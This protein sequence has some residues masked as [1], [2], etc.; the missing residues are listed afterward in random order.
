MSTL[1]QYGHF[2]EQ[3]QCFVLTHE[4][5]RKWRNVHY[6]AIGE[7]EVYAETSNIGDGPITV[8]DGRGITCNL[9]GWDAKYIYLRDDDNGIAFCPWGAPAPQQVQNRQCRFY[10]AKT[11]IASECNGLRLT[12]R[13]FVPRQQVMEI[14][15][16]TVENLT[17]KPRHL[18]VFG[19]AMFQLSGCD[20]EGRYVGKENYA[21]VMPE[22]GGTFITNR[23]TGAPSPRFK[24]YLVALNDFAGGN[25]YRDQFTRSEFS[26]GTPK[27]LWGWNC[28]NQPA[29]GP[30]C[31]GIVQAKIT[32]APRATGRV[33]FL[34]GQATCPEDVR[35]LRAGI[36]PAII[37]TWCDEQM[38]IETAR[39]A[40]FRVET[41][42]VNYD[43]LINIFVKKQM[44]SYLINKSGFRDNLQND[45][46]LAM[47][48][49]PAAEANLLRALASQY[50]NGSVPHGFR[51]LNRLQYSDK[52]AWTM[53]T[54]PALVKESGR[55]ALLDDIVPYFESSEKGTVWDHMLRAMRFLAKD[56]G[57]HG[58]CNQHHADW[59]DGLEATKEAGERESVMVTQQ[60]CYGLLE[61]EELARRRG[62]TAVQQEAR[63]IYD[64]FAK[65]LNEI[66]WDGEWY[67]RTFCGDGYKIGSRAN[68]EGQIF[69]NTQSWAV[70]SRTA[71]P[72]RA[73][74][75]MA[76]VDRLIS[77]DLGYRICVPGFSA[78]DPR[79][80]RMSNSMP[81]HVENG[82]CYNHA[83]GFKGV[84]DC[85]LGRAEQAWETFVKVAPDNPR[86]PIS[87]SGVEPFS[88][89]NSYSMCEYIYGQAGY[90]WRTGTASWFAVLLVEWILG[91]RRAYD[92]L[93][94]DPCL[95]K[96]VPRARV[97][98]S[99]RGA[100]YDITLDN[101]AGRCTGARSITVD[102]ARIDGNILPP[103]TSGTH[104][105][106]VLI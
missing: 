102:G 61:V 21:V 64:T 24:G 28:D 51:P 37:D 59:N 41:G 90:P 54:I 8:R 4:P 72:D 73:Q 70:L 103:F 55:M 43:G 33:D 32:V 80:G 79:V 9:V 5:P 74:Q 29:Y 53:L 82:G 1:E 40:T 88:F 60:L 46:G 35:T 98:R 10:A 45:C 101:T 12:Q 7:H 67:V 68:K 6:N 49:Y 47:A 22:I 30:D 85:M 25:S 104:T 50:A 18:S 92:G 2:D 57:Q 42:N 16:V 19:Y 15:T 23:N 78:Y 71:P 77:V 97:V 96:T 48:D 81:G 86:N 105:V 65:R 11:E 69:V 17:D 26:L 63:A 34:V 100:R 36:T 31:A 83:A 39:A 75:C 52:P 93:L 89:T 99:F 66:A 27:L 87:R 3:Q 62:D 91:A 106:A 20:A 58:L 13:V 84:A 38:A 44:Y 76:A 56:T 94:I 95:S 14:W